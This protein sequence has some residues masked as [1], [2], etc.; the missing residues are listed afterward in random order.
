M[1]RRNYRRNKHTT[2]LPAYNA[3]SVSLGHG[4]SHQKGNSIFLSVLLDLCVALL[5]FRHLS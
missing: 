3:P 1:R 5:V 2:E 4:F